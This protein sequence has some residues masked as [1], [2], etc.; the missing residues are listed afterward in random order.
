MIL[1]SIIILVDIAEIVEAPTTLYVGGTGGGNYS[2]L[3]WAI[4]NASA[5]DT[6]FVYNGTYYENV[7]VDKAINLIGEDINTT[8]IDGDYKN[9]VIRITVDYV[10]VTG[11]FITGCGSWHEY[12]G[13]KLDSVQ[14]CRIYNNNVSSNW[15]HGIYL[16]N[17]NYNNV[18]KNLA[19]MNDREGI[20]LYNSS[21]N[22]IT[23]NILMTNY[24]MGIRLEYSSRNIITNNY[25]DYDHNPDGWGISLVFNSDNNT[26][27]NNNISNYYGG[28]RLRTSCKWNTIINNDISFT[29]KYGIESTG[30]QWNNI[31]NNT[32]SECYS[33][34]WIGDDNSSIVGNRVFNNTYTGITLSGAGNNVV[35]NNLSYNGRQGLYGNSKNQNNITSNFFTG[36]GRWSMVFSSCIGFNLQNNT[37]INEGIYFYGASVENW[38]SHNIPT[39]NTVNGDPVQYWKNQTGGTIPPGAGQVI[40]ANCTNVKVDSQEFTITSEAIILG[41]S[42]GNVITANNIS[43][44]N[45]DGIHVIYSH[46]NLIANNT[47]LTLMNCID[48]WYSEGNTISGNTVTSSTNYDGISLRYSN[49]NNVSGNYPSNC[50]SGIHIE[51][52]D[53]NIITDNFLQDNYWGIRLSTSSNN[54]IMKNTAF[55]SSS[56][57]IYL[58]S[59]KDNNII[60]NNIIN[61]KKG[62]YL[63]GSTNNSI[64]HNNLI[65]NT[66]QANDNLAADNQWDSG[67]PNGGNFWSDYFGNDSFNGPDQDIPGGDG[68]GDTNYSI[69]A[70]TF[71]DYPLMSPYGNYSYL[72]QGWNLISFPF[73]QPETQLGSVLSSISGSYDAVQFYNA[74]QSSGQWIHNHITKPSYLNKLDAINH[75]MGLWIHITEPNGTLFKYPG[76]QPTSNQ[77]IT[78]HPGWN[79]VGYPS[80][81]NRTRDNALNNLNYGSDVDSIWTF[82]AATQTWQEIGPTDYFELGRGY[83]IHSK[84]TKVWDVPL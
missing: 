70:D 60:E 58:T 26:F 66:N 4:E 25:I 62:I 11:F 80:L 44:S 38:N 12:A 46:N 67:Y 57:G 31:F 27:S 53:L 52:S 3:Q 17:S 51:D 9:V 75:Y 2:K 65:N 47:A 78:L 21:H 84:V 45:R 76:T 69:D 48:L 36:N 82:N 54:T 29:A 55:L 83:W 41:F 8:I 19:F 56:S 50:P 43:T 40:L 68:I 6:V 71:D 33:G 73:V 24:D 35:L 64:Y 22:N 79:L 14:Y 37:M 74:S 1:S 20:Y 32:I 49:S 15:E 23:G 63:S 34:I 10:N 42:S 81:S 18:T 7:I 39:S 30:G 16:S 72:Y 5:G 77:S 13:I 28:I 61:N 59:S